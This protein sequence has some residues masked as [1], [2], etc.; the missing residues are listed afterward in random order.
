MKKYPFLLLSSFG[1]L[2]I[3]SCGSP[4]KKEEQSE[5][6]QESTV[7][8]E[9][10]ASTPSVNTDSLVSLIDEARSKAEQIKDKP[11]EL[12]TEKMREKIKQKWAS[13]HFYMTDGKLARIKTYPHDKISKRTEEFYV[14]DDALVLAVIEDDGSGARGKAAEKLNKMYYFHQNDLIKEVNSSDEPE[15][16]VKKSDAEELLSEFG[17]YLQI[18]KTQKP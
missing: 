16:S 18:F 13:I 14:Q 7:P 6:K 12:K 9:E 11:L 1:L 8:S 10:T 15:Q 5:V 2:F 4:E 17:E 3:T